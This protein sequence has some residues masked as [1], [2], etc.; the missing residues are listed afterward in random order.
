MGKRI[1]KI[2]KI[3]MLLAF[4]THPREKKKLRFNVLQR[5]GVWGERF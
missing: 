5:D 4:Q 3:T 1:R 2:E